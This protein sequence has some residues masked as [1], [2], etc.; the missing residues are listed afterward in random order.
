MKDLY[1]GALQWPQTGYAHPY[2]VWVSYN[3][4]VEELFERADKQLPTGWK[5]LVV[6]VPQEQSKQEP[7]ELQELLKTDI[8]E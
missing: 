3:D 4:R 5:K 2:R 7:N 8:Y 6:D 1:S